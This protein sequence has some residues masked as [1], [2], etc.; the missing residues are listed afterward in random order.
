MSTSKDWSWDESERVVA[1]LG[2]V[3]QPGEHVRELSPSADGERFAMVLE[4]DATSAS[5][6]VNGERWPVELEKAWKL[7]HTADGRTLALV[8]VDDQWTVIVDG[9]LWES[10]FEFAW[11]PRLSSD[12]KTIAV[13]VKREMQHAVAVNDRAWEK[14]FISIRDYTLSADGQHVAAAA[15]VEELGEADVAGFKAGTWGVVVD[16]EPWAERF[17]NAWAPIFSPDQRSVAAEVRTGNCEYTIARDGKVWPQRY[18]CIWE[19]RFRNGEEI[20]VPVRQG[21]AWHLVR[22]GEK[23]WPEPFVQLWHQVLSPST[24]GIAAVVA[25]G[26][27]RWTVAVDGRAWK[28]TFSDMVSRP[29]FSADGQH[30]AAAFCD[31]GEWGIAVD[32]AP[33]PERFV[34]AGDPVA[35]P[36]AHFAAVVERNG[37][38]S[39]AVDGVVWARSFDR[40]WDPC[41]DPEGKNL[42]VRG[43]I[44]NRCIR[45]VVPVRQIQGS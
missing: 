8:R 10:R 14:S 20:I 42:L 37:R 35:G 2:G 13:Q 24:E 19:P 26:Y 32:G 16:G 33:W 15:Q 18:G 43:V 9:K 39:L 1:D 5:V 23:L 40:L 17:V 3:A 45:Q 6:A 25:T 36:G 41:F 7:G 30:V 34:M 4:K 27:G 11:N 38:Q 22:N 44:D 28:R 12:G 29:V 21:G 31:E